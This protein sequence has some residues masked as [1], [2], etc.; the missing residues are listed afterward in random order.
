MRTNLTRAAAHSQRIDV[1]RPRLSADREGRA[2]PGPAV[3]AVRHRAGHAV[4]SHAPLRRPPAKEVAAVPASSVAH[5]STAPF[6]QLLGLWISRRDAPQF[7]R[8][9]PE[10]EAEDDARGLGCRVCPDMGAG[11]GGGR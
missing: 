9:R 10:A 6:L 4:A 3:E 7:E 5:L 2:R 8:R 11:R 1:G